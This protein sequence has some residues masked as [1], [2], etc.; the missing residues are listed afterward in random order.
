MLAG[1]LWTSFMVYWCRGR[2]AWSFHCWLFHHLDRWLW[3]NIVFTDYDPLT[4]PS[5]WQ[6]WLKITFIIDH[7]WLLLII[8]DCEPF[9]RLIIVDDQMYC[10]LRLTNATIYYDCVHP[11]RSSHGNS[12]T[13]VVHWRQR[14]TPS[15]HG[16]GYR[17]LRRSRD[18]PRP[19]ST[20]ANGWPVGNAGTPKPWMMINKGVR[21]YL[22]G[23]LYDT[24]LVVSRCSF[25]LCPG[26]LPR[27]WAYSREFAPPDIHGIPVTFRGQ[28]WI[29]AAIAKGRWLF[30]IRF[31]W[32][33]PLGGAR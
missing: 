7:Y 30:L 5:S 10:W 8:T 33:K 13:L 17:D 25:K 6:Y 22:V 24:W 18:V 14:F 27:W 20:G 29:Q 1:W 28:K 21:W 9:L 16:A 2:T 31:C 19:G 15:I 12:S 26:W 3:T 23:G 4:H 32:R 11:G